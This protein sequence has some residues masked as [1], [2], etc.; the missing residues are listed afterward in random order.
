MGCQSTQILTKV[1]VYRV[2]LAGFDTGRQHVD[3]LMAMAG[4]FVSSFRIVAW[5]G[6]RAVIVT[7]SSRHEYMS[8]G[9]VGCNMASCWILVAISPNL[10]GP[11]DMNSV[12]PSVMVSSNADACRNL[13][14]SCACL[15]MKGIHFCTDVAGLVMSCILCSL[16]MFA[17]RKASYPTMRE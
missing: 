10:S 11:G 4:G 12:H 2:L 6:D 16:R 13:C 1:R 9:K 8:P 17:N 14:N 3:A 5:Y 15:M 7:N